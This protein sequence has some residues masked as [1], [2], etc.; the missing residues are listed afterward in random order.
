MIAARLADPSFRIKVTINPMRYSLILP[1]STTTLWSLTQAPVIFFNV[2]LA[3]LMPSAV[4]TSKPL[5]E[6]EIISVT[7][8]TAMLSQGNCIWIVTNR[9]E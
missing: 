3:L 4:A 8:A 1:S 2:L 6:E 9:Y 7:R 5:F